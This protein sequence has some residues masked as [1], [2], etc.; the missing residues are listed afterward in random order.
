MRS[1]LIK[2][3]LFEIKI[4]VPPPPI[5]LISCFQLHP[6]HGSGEMNSCIYVAVKIVMS[7]NPYLEEENRGLLQFCIQQI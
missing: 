6:K 7:L 5:V 2:K 3:C 1:K 4:D